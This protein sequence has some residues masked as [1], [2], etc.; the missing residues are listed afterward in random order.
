MNEL[1]EQVAEL[2]VKLSAMARV[3]TDCSCIDITNSLKSEVQQLQSAVESQS[4][5]Y[6]DASNKS[7]K[8]Q[9][10]QPNKTSSKRPDDVP[11]QTY[12][13]KV[14]IEGSRKVWG[15]LEDLSPSLR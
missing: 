2:K 13:S 5:T 11:N 9:R 12:R 14:K 7:F 10:Q 6:A 8:I 15:V 1:K 3:S 4:S